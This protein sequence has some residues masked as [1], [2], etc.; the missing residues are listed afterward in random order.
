[1]SFSLAVRKPPSAPTATKPTVF[2]PLSE[3]EPP[4][5]PEPEPQAATLTRAAADATRAMAFFQFFM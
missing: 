4:L 1:M 2:L 5:S 3:L